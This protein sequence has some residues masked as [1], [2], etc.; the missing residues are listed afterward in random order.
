MY[1]CALY[2][3]TTSCAKDIALISPECHLKLPNPT[4]SNDLERLA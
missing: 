1:V 2:A 4:N 3:Y